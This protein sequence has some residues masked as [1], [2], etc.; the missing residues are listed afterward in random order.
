M[1]G[2]GLHEVKSKAQACLIRTFLETA[3]N[4][5]FLHSSFHTILY[6]VYVLQDDSISPPPLPPP[7]FSPSFF[8]S[9]KWVKDNTPLNIATMTTNQWYRV[10]LEKEVTMEDY[11]DSPNVY[12][13]CRAELS[14]PTTDWETSWRRAR[15][16]GIGSDGTSFLWKMLH[17]LLPTEARLSRIL[18]NSSEQ[19]KLCPAPATA[20]LTHCL[21]ACVSTRE[22]GNWLLSLVRQHDP[23]A[24][25]QKLVR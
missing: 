8:S 12:K 14:S 9:I 2:L 1:G 3:L 10:L 18:P 25:T 6:R 19:C 21:F 23:T 13:K 15:L 22:A 7:Y 11:I 24:T 17:N 16:K 4:P 20:D 5:L